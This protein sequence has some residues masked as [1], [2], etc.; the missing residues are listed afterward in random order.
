MAGNSDGS[1]P[2]GT[3]E[4][5]WRGVRGY[6]LLIVVDTL[7]YSVCFM[8]CGV[9]YYVIFGIV[10]GLSAVIP[11]LGMIVA[12]ALTVV[13][14]ALAGASLLQLLSVGGVFL[15]YGCV[16]EQFFV[17]PLLVGKALNLRTWEVAVAMIAG[18][19]IAGPLGM[20]LALPLWGTVKYILTS[21]K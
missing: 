8:F 1:L 7:V 6:T 2:R 20:L 12:A 3:I 13:A 19:L 9:P 4:Y 21:R 15:V 10:S 11:A 5:L 16:I 18:L 17:Y 14:S